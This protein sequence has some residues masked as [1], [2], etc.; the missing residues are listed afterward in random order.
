[1]KQQIALALNALYP[2]DRKAMIVL[3]G[4]KKSS[5]LQ[6]STMARW[7]NVANASTADAEVKA[8]AEAAYAAIVLIHRHNCVGARRALRAASN[9]GV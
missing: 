1:M 6:L 5:A 8:Q 7:V 9:L 2:I 4:D 3:I